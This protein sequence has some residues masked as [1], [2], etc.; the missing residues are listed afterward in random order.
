[1]FWAFV[2]NRNLTNNKNFTAITLE[3]CT[4]NVLCQLSVGYY[5]LFLWRCVPIR[6]IAYSSWRCLD[7]TQRHRTVGRT[8]LDEWSARHRD[9]YQ[10]TH[11]THNSKTSMP[12]AGFE[13]AISAPLSIK[14]KKTTHSRPY[15]CMAF[16][17][18]CDT[19]TFPLQVS[20]QALYVHAV[21][22]SYW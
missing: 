3:K 22:L 17:L 7:H 8:P 5:L 4:V 2:V 21:W 11:N 12:P 14:L 10:I 16:C 9:L 6:A 19:M 13:T 20:F 18:C 1:M 15:A